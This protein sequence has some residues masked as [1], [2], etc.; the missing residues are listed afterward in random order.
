MQLRS[1]IK[2]Q[3]GEA[4]TKL[5]AELDKVAA[6]IAASEAALDEYYTRRD[7]TGLM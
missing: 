2:T 7:D 4:R 6:Q 1:E 3:T 5:Q